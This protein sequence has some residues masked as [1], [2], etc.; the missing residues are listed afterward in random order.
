VVVKSDVPSK[1]SNHTNGE[2]A[3]CKSSK[4]RLK[5]FKLKV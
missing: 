3:G 1:I 2:N 4:I 5:G